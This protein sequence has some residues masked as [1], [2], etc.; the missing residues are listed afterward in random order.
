MRK[1]NIPEGYI[2]L[3]QDM[4]RGATTRVKS[5][6]G[7]SEHFEVGIGLHQGSALSPFLFIMLIDTI[8]QDVRTELPWE[9]LY[10]DD[11]AIIDITSTDTQNRLE[12]WQKI[13]TDNGLKINVA[14]TEHLSTR[15]NPLPMTLNGEELKHVDHFKYLGSVIDKDGTIDKDV[16]L[17]VQAAWSSWRKLTGVLYDRMIPLRLKAKVYEAIIRPALTYGS[18]CWAMKVTNKRKIATTEMRMLRGILGVSR[19]ART[20]AKRGHPT[21]TTHYT[22]RRGY[23]RWP[24]SLVRSCPETRRRQRH[25]QSDGAGNTRCQTT[26]TAQEDEASS[27]QRR[28]DGRGCYRG[29]GPR[30]KRVEEKDTADP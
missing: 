3:V 1:Q 10:A 29:C 17:R 30:P 28:H 5:K 15:E 16:D 12:S 13:L 14:K 18:E 4:Y 6:R 26:R 9:L 11:L 2:R 27:N 19:R 23:A 24:S 25:P 20:H 7:M 22:Y 21:H 8:S